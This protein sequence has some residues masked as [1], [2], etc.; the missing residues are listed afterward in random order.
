MVDDSDQSAV[1][2]PPAPIARSLPATHANP[3]AL[4]SHLLRS[5]AV[6]QALLSAGLALTVEAVRL[7]LKRR[8]PPAT[9][10]T[11]PGPRLT[12][13]DIPDQETHL[14]ISM[15]HWERWEAWTARIL[16]DEG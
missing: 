11:R 12:A 4:A 15:V 1:E 6:R 14:S 5:P 3:A 10:L 16:E 7:V 8:S 13:P 2:F 9:R